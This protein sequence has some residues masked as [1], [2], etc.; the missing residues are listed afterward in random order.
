MYHA[1]FFVMPFYEFEINICWLR[2]VELGKILILLNF[3]NIVIFLIFFNFLL[4]LCETQLRFN[5]TFEL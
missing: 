5:E 3:G 4:E 2:S 1:N